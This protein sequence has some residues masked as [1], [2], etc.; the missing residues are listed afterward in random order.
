LG[1]L[2]DKIYV[3]SGSV[4]DQDGDGQRDADGDANLVQPT[5]RVAIPTHFYKI[6]L[7][8][9]PNGFIESMT[10]LL[11]HVDSSPTFQQA[12]PFLR[13]HLTNID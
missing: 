10:F 6:I 8:E 3:I 1:K 11:P 13:N 9:R 2:R 12:K 4:F 7:H 5:D